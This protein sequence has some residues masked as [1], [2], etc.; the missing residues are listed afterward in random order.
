[1]NLERREG[2]VDTPSVDPGKSPL[3]VR[4][5]DRNAPYGHFWSMPFVRVELTAS[6]DVAGPRR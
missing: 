1:M 2:L 6:P 4:L 5:P 3:E